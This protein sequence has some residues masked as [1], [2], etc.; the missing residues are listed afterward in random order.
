MVQRFPLCT[1]VGIAL[2]LSGTSPQG[3]AM[4]KHDVN[5]NFVPLK[6]EYIDKVKSIRLVAE[7]G[8]VY[9]ALVV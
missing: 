2:V 8:Q 9:I 4:P 1:I 3:V 7:N 5:I 6:I